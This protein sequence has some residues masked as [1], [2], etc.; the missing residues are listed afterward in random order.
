MSLNLGSVNNYLTNIYLHSS[1][2]RPSLPIHSVLKLWPSK[3]RFTLIHPFS[4]VPSFK[5]LM[6][7]SDLGAFHLA[8]PQI[9]NEDK[10]SAR[11]CGFVGRILQGVRG[12]SRPV[13]LRTE[14]VGSREKSE[15]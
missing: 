7:L 14:K 1:I 6:V 9:S 12:V 5:P 8:L 13:E 11:I 2:C 15:A 4:Y 10:S 3:K